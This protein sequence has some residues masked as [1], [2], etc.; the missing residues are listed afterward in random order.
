MRLYVTCSKD[1]SVSSD[2]VERREMI[3]YALSNVQGL[4]DVGT[5]VTG[6]VTTASRAFCYKF[7]I[8]SS[9]GCPRN[10]CQRSAV[11]SIAF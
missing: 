4:Q 11:A 1:F 9:P 8:A 3:L 7:L 2:C 6:L 10:T 5:S